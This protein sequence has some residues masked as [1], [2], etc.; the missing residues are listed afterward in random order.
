MTLFN[1]QGNALD[2]IKVLN[3]PCENLLTN[4]SF[5]QNGITT[6]PSGWNVWTSDSSD[7]NT[8]R[9]EYGDAYDGDYKL[10][11]GMIKSIR[12][13]YIKRIQIFRMEHINSQFGQRQMGNRMFYNFMQKL[14]RK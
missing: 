5:E 9:T 10:T 14:W 12:V 7:E 11:F 1:F 2:S 6:S 8:V 4:I 3:K 13:L